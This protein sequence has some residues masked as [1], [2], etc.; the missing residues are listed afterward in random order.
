M[1]EIEAILSGVRSALETA[2]VA[3]VMT[4]FPAGEKKRFTEPVVALGV[5]AGES[6]SAGFSEYMGERYD[7]DDD[8]YYEIYGKK[9]E[10]TLGVDIYAPKESGAGACLDVLAKIIAALPAL[11]SG[12]R[13]KR[14]SCGETGFDAGTGMLLLK[15]D[16]PCLCFMYADNTGDSELLDF[17]LKGVLTD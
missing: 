14:F 6:V 13:I 4:A 9:L 15:A 8:A 2:E 10:L 16:M 11:P 7:E 12:I 3:D 17:T 1:T 5:R